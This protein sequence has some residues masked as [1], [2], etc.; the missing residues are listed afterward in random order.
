MLVKKEKFCVNSYSFKNSDKTIPL[1][2]GYETYGTLNQAKNNVILVCHYFTGTSHAAGKYTDA[3]QLP[4]W[5]DALIGPRKPI[6]TD[7]YFVISSDSLSNI[8]CY[9]PNVITTGPASINP[10][11]GKEYG[12][13]FP[14]F[15]LHDVVHLQK[16]LL[17]S[18]GIK[19]LAAV[20]G[21][22]MGGLQAFIWG[23][24]FPEAVEKIISVVATP[25]VTPFVLMVPNQLGIDAIKS[26][27]NWNNGNYYGKTAPREGLLNAFKVLLMI[28]RTDHWADTSFGRKFADPEFIN[29]SD[30]RK[31]FSGKYL[32][33]TEVEKIVIDR[34]KFFDANSYMYIAKANALYDLAEPGETLEQALAKITPPTL[35]IIDESD[36]IFNVRQ[37]KIAE[38]FLPNAR[39][40]YYNSGNGHLSCL[41]DHQLFGEHI[42]TFLKG[43]SR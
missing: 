39:T 40:A 36:L 10:Q 41:F 24:L 19:R 18:L 31:S 35:M 34:M 26:D 9:N 21:P 2:I 30:P 14:I 43:S 15:T 7:K 17:N 5:W 6:D 1:E 32:I 13:D 4:G 8:N 25:M 12:L 23:R 42:R 16:M 11:T 38:K 22:S 3:D 29:Y 20:I 37:A 27:P 28:T 33:E